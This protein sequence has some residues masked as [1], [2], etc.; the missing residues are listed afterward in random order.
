MM[1]IVYFKSGF[2]QAFIV[3]RNIIALEFQHLAEEIGGG[4]SRIEFT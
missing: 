3:P 2:R 4:I 1:I